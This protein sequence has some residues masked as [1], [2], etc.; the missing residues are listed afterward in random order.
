MT[1]FNQQWRTFEGEPVT[2]MTPTRMIVY[3]DPPG[4]TMNAQQQGFVA[5][6]YR[7]FCDAIN[8]SPHRDGFHAQN[9]VAPDGTKVRMESI[10]GVHTVKVWIT[11]KTPSGEPGGLYL[12]L[13]YTPPAGQNF[14]H[15]RWVLRI[16]PDLTRAEVVFAGRAR[17][18]QT[19]EDE[20]IGVVDGEVLYRRET[21]GPGFSEWNVTQHS[22]LYQASYLHGNPPGGPAQTFTWDVKTFTAFRTRSTNGSQIRLGPKTLWSID[23]HFYAADAPSVV[24]FQSQKL[25]HP[26]TVNRPGG[27]LFRLTR[28]VTT[29][30]ATVRSAAFEVAGVHPDFLFARRASVAGRAQGYRARGTSAMGAL[31]PNGSATQDIDPWFSGSGLTMTLDDLWEIDSLSNG[32]NVAN[33]M[34]EVTTNNIEYWRIKSGGRVSDSGDAEIRWAAN[35]WFVPRQVFRG[36]TTYG[37]GFFS[38]FSGFPGDD[39]LPAGILQNVSI[40]GQHIC[41]TDYSILA[42]PTPNLIGRRYARGSFV[43]LFDLNTPTAS[44]VWS[45]ADN[46]ITDV[47]G[48][49]DGFYG[50]AFDGATSRSRGGPVIFLSRYGQGNPEAICR[51]SD[52]LPDEIKT[53]WEEG[54]ITIPVWR[55]W[56]ANERMASFKLLLF[57]EKT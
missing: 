56:G 38:S 6:V 20:P 15:R 42:N 8:V 41:W 11:Q 37:P 45:A 35:P 57:R 26:D 7:L 36:L 23:S 13:A 9:R 24:T 5:H 44:A 18:A 31:F 50:I 39:P 22:T 40:D 46:Q 4:L 49:K 52:L 51:L 12:V 29:E 28:Q 53:F 33:L 55:P 17:T 30:P 1:L 34:L 19:W 43:P 21:A 48:L 16:E 2:G 54:L 10:N 47:V 14:G 32:Q 27:S 25:P 3:P